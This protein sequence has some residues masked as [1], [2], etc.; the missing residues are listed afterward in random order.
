ME[1]IPP[2]LATTPGICPL[3]LKVFH[4]IQR[5]ENFRLLFSLLN[6]IQRGFHAEVRGFGG[7]EHLKANAHRS[8]PLSTQV[9]F[10][11]E[12]LSGASSHVDHAR[13]FARN[14]NRQDMVTAG[15]E[16][17]LIRRKKISKEGAA[18]VAGV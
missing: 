1:S 18:V 9:I 8:E 14:V 10:P 15:V 13:E 16:Q 3:R 2:I 11:G 5:G 6:S 17:R 4:R 12:F 7:G